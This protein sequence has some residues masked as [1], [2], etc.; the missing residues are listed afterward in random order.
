MLRRLEFTPDRLGAKRAYTHK[1]SRHQKVPQISEK[2]PIWLRIVTSDLEERSIAESPKHRFGR[3][4]GS[5]IRNREP[6]A[7]GLIA[8]PHLNGVD[9]AFCK[10]FSSGGYFAGTGGRG[11]L[12]G[13]LRVRSDVG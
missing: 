12:S 9:G 13:T 1:H 5:S 2:F 4:T 11:K 10:K 3:C 8:L 6:N 7:W